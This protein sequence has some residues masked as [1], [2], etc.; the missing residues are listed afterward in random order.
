MADVG[1]NKVFEND[2]IRVWE[3]FLGPGERNARHTH[4]LAYVCY[5]V[6]GSTLRAFDADGQKAATV[7]ARRSGEVV[8]F[9]IEG[10]EFVSGSGS[11]EVRVPATHSVQNIGVTP[12]REILIEFKT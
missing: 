10:S 7:E 12:Y 3:L 4:K 5:V 6:E 8:P 1:T 9:H 11:A 2:K